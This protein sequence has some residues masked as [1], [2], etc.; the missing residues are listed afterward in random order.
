M[1]EL[2]NAGARYKLFKCKAHVY[3]VE[4]FYLSSSQSSV[5]VEKLASASLRASSN[6]QY[7]LYAALW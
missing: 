5:I 2:Y 6:P 1:S 3:E 4:I 7:G